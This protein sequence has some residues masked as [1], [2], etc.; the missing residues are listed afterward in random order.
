MEEHEQA[1]V[2]RV[3]ERKPCAKLKG[4]S[5]DW[6]RLISRSHGVYGRNFGRSIRGR[7]SEFIEIAH[8]AS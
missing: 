3:I 6:K 4:V 8:H 1:F 7:S 5:F 2:Q